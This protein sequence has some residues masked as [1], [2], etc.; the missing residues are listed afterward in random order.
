LIEGPWTSPLF[1]RRDQTTKAG[2]NIAI[3]L[4]KVSVHQ[5]KPLVHIYV[6]VKPG[7]RIGELN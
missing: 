6:D 7:C 2:Y 1:D 5:S 4:D 3:C